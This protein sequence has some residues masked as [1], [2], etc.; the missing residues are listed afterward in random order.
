MENVLFGDEAKEKLIEGVNII[1][2]A[3][4]S[5]F[6][7]SGKNVFIKG[8]SK[9]HIT[10]DGATVARYVSSTDPFIDMGIELVRNIAT[11][12]ADDVG[13]GTTSSCILA[14]EIVN[15]LKDSKEHPITI[16][17][18]L[19]E[20]VK[21]VIDYLD[22]HKK[23]ITTLEDLIK[24]ATVSTNNDPILGKLIAETYWNVT[25]N[26]IVTVEE[27]NDTIDSV[28]YFSGI[29]VESGYMSPY[30]M[31]T[32]KNECIL[33]NVIVFISDLKVD[34]FTK[35]LQT[36]CERAIKEKKSV[37]LI[38]P[39]ID[40]SVMMIMLNNSRQGTF[41]SCCV[42]TP[43]HGVYR[44]YT[45]KDLRIS[46]GESMEC[47]K[48]IITKDS[49]VFLDTIP[50]EELKRQEIENINKILSNKETLEF[51]INFN[52][53]RLA[54]YTGGGATIYVGGYSSVE[55][56]EKKDRIEDAI[57][58]VKAAFDG[59]IL[60]GGGTALQKASM[61]L[62]LNYLKDIIIR[63]KQILVESAESVYSE[64]KEFWVGDDFKNNKT[65]DMYELGIIDPFLVTKVSLENAVNAASMIL[66]TGVSII[67]M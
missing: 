37:L 12:T 18:K 29:K 7:P 55:I 57:C 24:V 66:T 53:K 2:D 65:G 13:D 54:N 67:N 6:G 11:K 38:A 9:L 31:N 28:K 51:D 39:K 27:S 62:D 46:L 61:N 41:K 58:A 42:I 21:T 33:E 49:T 5:T 44:E 23:E 45:L 22:Y 14:A 47:K 25:K 36:T 17:R 3:V 8:V 52:K 60:P 4:S 15:K 35:E 16:S 43:N 20:D 30:F 19:N 63:P 1:N 59:G 10:K 48:V 50:N 26:G 64:H 32:E 34:D 40:S 56:L